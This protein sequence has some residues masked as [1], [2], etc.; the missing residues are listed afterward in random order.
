MCSYRDRCRSP[1]RESTAQRA[2]VAVTGL[3]KLL[4]TPA[5]P[6]AEHMVAVDANVTADARE[7][8]FATG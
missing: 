6:G 7:L 2:E 1:S 8:L 5:L 4:L 3:V